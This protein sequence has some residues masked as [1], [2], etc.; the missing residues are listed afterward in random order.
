MGEIR[1]CPVCSSIKRRCDGLFVMIPGSKGAGEFVRYHSEYCPD[2]GKPISDAAKREVVRRAEGLN[3]L[4]ADIHKNA[5]EHGWYEKPREIPEVIALMHAELSEAL[6]AYRNGEPM[7]YAKTPG[8]VCVGCDNAECDCEDLRDTPRCSVA[9][10]EGVAVEL[11][12]CI[13]RILDTLAYCNVDIDA[14]I[15]SKHEYNKT[16]TYRHGGKLC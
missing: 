6:E 16:R 4:A 11:A 12:D 13:I 8:N 10:P 7:V 2:C 3:A 14:V 1:D 5:V 15:R 9:K